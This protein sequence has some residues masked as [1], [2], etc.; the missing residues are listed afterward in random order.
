MP[1]MSETEIICWLCHVI[2]LPTDE[3][4]TSSFWSDTNYP[5][6]VNIV[7]LYNKL[8]LFALERYRQ[9]CYI[10]TGKKV[11]F[12]LVQTMM[13]QRESRVITLLFLQPRD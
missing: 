12:V 9:K 8:F 13:V 5:N 4:C 3:L 10:P 11:N 1:Q 7:F 6:I 2:I